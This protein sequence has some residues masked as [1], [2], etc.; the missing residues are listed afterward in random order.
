MNSVKINNHYSPNPFKTIVLKEKC[1]LSSTNNE[2]FSFVK[3]FKRVL[4][5]NGFI[6]TKEILGCCRLL[7]PTGVEYRYLL[8]KSGKIIRRCV[9]QSVKATYVRQPA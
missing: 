8:N 7:Q 4:L 3:V 9:I 2:G 5:A 1:K 6:M